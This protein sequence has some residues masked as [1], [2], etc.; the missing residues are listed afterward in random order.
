MQN[1]IDEKGIK[2]G[3]SAFQAMKDETRSYNKYIFQ[4]WVIKNVGM[5]YLSKNKIEEAIEIFKLNVHEYPESW[6]VY[7][8][9]ADAYLKNQNIPLAIEYYEKALER[10]PD[11]KKIEGVLNRLKN[12]DD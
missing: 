1:T 3:I 9:L 4:E 12:H 7:S 5:Y 6:E 11:N 8:D 10:N 2:E